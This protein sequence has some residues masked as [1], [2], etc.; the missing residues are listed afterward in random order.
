MRFKSRYSK[1][2][3]MPVPYTYYGKVRNAYT[4]LVKMKKKDGK[5]VREINEQMLGCLNI[6]ILTLIDLAA[7]NGC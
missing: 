1:A 7:V 5:L 3:G 6:D 4:Y 2:A